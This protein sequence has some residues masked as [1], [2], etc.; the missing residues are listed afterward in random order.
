MAWQEASLLV[1]DDLAE[2]RLGGSVVEEAPGLAVV[3]VP[4]DI[5]LSTPAIVVVVFVVASKVLAV[6]IPG[7][8]AID[9]VFLV[10]QSA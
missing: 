6:R 3:I 10:L 8:P 2:R 1:E 5:G 4:V 7:H 9:D